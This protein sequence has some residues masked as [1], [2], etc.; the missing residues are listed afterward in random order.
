MESYFTIH[1]SSP[2]EKR[3]PISHKIRDYF[4]DFITEHVLKSKK[5]VY[6]GN[7]MV[8][9]AIYFVN[10]CP[11]S[12][13]KRIFFAKRARTIST[14]KVKMYEVSISVK[15]IEESNNPLLT[16]IE[17]MYEAISAFFTTTYKKVRPEFMATL[18]KE[19]DLNYLL[20]LPYPA[21]FKDQ[22]YLLDEQLYTI[23]SDGSVR[24]TTVEE[25]ASRGGYKG[26]LSGIVMGGGAKADRR[27]HSHKNEGK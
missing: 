25:L 6:G 9:L 23:E 21:P 20:V 3:P 1:Q 17:L 11:K 22:Q 27:S 18:W 8:L 5:I 24:P 2:S 10:A 4:E 19:V 16:T 14:D 12:P 15:P 7:W 13:D 26:K